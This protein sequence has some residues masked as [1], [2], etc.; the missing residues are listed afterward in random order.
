MNKILIEIRNKKIF[1][2]D[3]T[4]NYEAFKLKILFMACKYVYNGEIK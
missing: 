1:Y 4:L 2:Y 3:S